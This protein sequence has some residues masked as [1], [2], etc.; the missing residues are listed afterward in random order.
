MYI[1]IAD[2]E[3]GAGEGF[4]LHYFLLL[5]NLKSE[6]VLQGPVLLEKDRHNLAVRG[7]AGLREMDM[8]EADRCLEEEL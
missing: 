1:L 3:E 6:L 8:A 7:K 4:H 2:Q 5:S